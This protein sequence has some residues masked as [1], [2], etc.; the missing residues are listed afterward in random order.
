MSTTETTL[1]E[2]AIEA[3][4]NAIITQARGMTIAS[5][6]D[7]VA[8][9]QHVLDW[10]A[11][12]KEI[13]ATFDPI[14]KKAF[15]TKT[16]A[17]ESHRQALASKARHADPL[18]QAVGI[19]GQLVTKWNVEQARLAEVERLQA[20]KIED[21]KQRELQLATVKELKKSGETGMAEQVRQEPAWTAPPVIHNTTSYAPKVAGVSKP[22]DNFGYAI[23]TPGDML[24]LIK[25]VADGVAPPQALTMNAND[26]T[27]I[28]ALASL[29]VKGKVSAGA[30]T[31]NPV[32]LGQ[33]A[34]SLKTALNYPGVT[35]T[36]N[37]TTTFRT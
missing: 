15:E 27:A 22:K 32:F 6:D 5:A 33:Q 12:M 9:C 17:L 36:N 21:D 25:A 28:K 31:H 19:A 1:T 8:I 34:R 7:Y 4:V 3:K 26:P 24:L 35:V 13:D 23:K 20:Q 14:I 16:S 30:F 18:A 2:P 37:Q 29:V 10:K 11:T